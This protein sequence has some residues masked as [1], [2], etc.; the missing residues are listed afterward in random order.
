MGEKGKQKGPC[1]V[2]LDRA[3]EAKAVRN[4]LICVAH[5]SPEPG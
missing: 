3:E 4:R 1:A 2:E 5:L